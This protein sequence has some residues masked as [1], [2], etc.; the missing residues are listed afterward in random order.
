MPTSGSDSRRL[1]PAI[2][3]YGF[4]SD[5]HSAALVDRRGSIDWWCVP[6]FDSPSVLGRLL[7]PGA[8]HWQLC[9]VA[10]VLPRRAHQCRLAPQRGILGDRQLIREEAGD[11]GRRVSLSAVPVDLGPA[12]LSRR[13][14]LSARG[15]TQAAVEEL[16]R[17]RGGASVGQVRQ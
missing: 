7:D 3:D 11:H 15:S 10:G 1:Q 16:I 5:C 12:P 6:R 4:L 2:G 17:G 8:G 14:Y 9:P 13:P